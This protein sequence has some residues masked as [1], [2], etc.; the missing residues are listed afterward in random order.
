MVDWEMNIL[1]WLLYLSHSTYHVICLVG[2]LEKVEEMIITTS[3]HSPSDE[4]DISSL[5]GKMVDRERDRD[6]FF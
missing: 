6:K 5:H 3:S 4:T 1:F 2:R